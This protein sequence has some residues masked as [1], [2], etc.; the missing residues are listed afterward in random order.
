M[1]FEKLI[2]LWYDKRYRNIEEFLN[3]CW[4]PWFTK[5]KYPTPQWLTFVYLRWV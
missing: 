5:S 3:G 1:E 4:L 2:Y